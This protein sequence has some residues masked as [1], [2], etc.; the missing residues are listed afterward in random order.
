LTKQ[1]RDDIWEIIE[2]YMEYEQSLEEKEDI[3]EDG[4]SQE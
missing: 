1:G 2:D 3:V 4:L